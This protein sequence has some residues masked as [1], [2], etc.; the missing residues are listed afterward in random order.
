VSNSYPSEVDKMTGNK[1]LL[2]RQLLNV[3]STT[4]Y[5]VQ[6][7]PPRT[8]RQQASPGTERGTA[9][10]PTWSTV[11]AFFD[12]IARVST[13]AINRMSEDVHH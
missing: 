12:K 11:S 8:V 1:G 9:R 7:A 4:R 2:L 6:P 5:L 3:E 10:Y 13:T